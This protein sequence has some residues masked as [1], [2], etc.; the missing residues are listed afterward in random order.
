VSWSDTTAQKISGYLR[1]GTN[2]TEINPLF[3]STRIYL[4]N[5]VSGGRL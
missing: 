1:A 5:G 3:R 4:A 2:K